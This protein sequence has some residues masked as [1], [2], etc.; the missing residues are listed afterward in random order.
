MSALYDPN[1]LPKVPAAFVVTLVFDSCPVML[2][3]PGIEVPSSPIVP[4]VGACV[5]LY[6]DL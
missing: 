4:P 3:I 1:A 2:V 5:G 6:F